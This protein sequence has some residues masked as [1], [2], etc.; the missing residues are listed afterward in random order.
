MFISAQRRG[1]GATP[2]LIGRIDLGRRRVNDYVSASL[3][4]SF[5]CWVAGSA[6]D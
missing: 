3:A 4:A 5:A 1:L 2:E 6:K